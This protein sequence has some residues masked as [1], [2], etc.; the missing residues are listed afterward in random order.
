MSQKKHRIRRATQKIIENVVEKI[1]S[2]KVKSY[3]EIIKENW[4]FLVVLTIGTIIL[5]V[6]GMHGDF[7]SDDYAMI[8]NNPQIKDIGFAVK[9]FNVV[10]VS[11]YILAMTLGVVPWAYHTFS[12]LLYLIFLWIGFVFVYLIVEKRAAMITMLLFAVLPL[13]VEAVSWN[14]GKPYLYIAIFILL[15]FLFYLRYLSDNNKKYLFASLAAF[16]FIFVTDHPRPMALIPII[17][18]YLIIANSKEYWKKTTKLFP[19]LGVLLVIMTILAIPYIKTRIS[20]VNGGYNASESIF[21]NPFF[22]Y[23][24]GIPKYLQLMWMPFDLTLYHTMFVFPVKLNWMIFLNL[25][26]LIGYSYFK[27]KRIFFALSFF[28]VALLPSMAPVKVSWLVA[29]RY[30][31]LPSLGF[32]IFAGILLERIWVK[33]KYIIAIVLPVL[34]IFYAER[35]FLRNI[36]WQ[37]NHK[38]WVNT[39]QVSPNS[40]N[41]WNNIGDDYDKLKQFENAIKGFTQSTIVKVNYA[42]AYHNRANIFFKMGRL[43]LA[44]DS[45]NVA[46]YYSPTLYQTYLSL[47]QID[48][49]ENKLDLAIEH[50]SKAVEIEPTNPQA[51]YVLAVVYAQTGQLSQAQQLLESILR[52]APGYKPAE[53][54]LRQLK[55]S[56]IGKS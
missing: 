12:L 54:A 48:M 16:F 24:T 19:Y 6:N 15:S 35:T 3:R 47:T 14:S 50:A 51:A 55:L 43:D 11:N 32:C 45:Y 28:V 41:A 36:D 31:F 56:Q 8:L 53:D 30:G 10:D 17:G 23:P 44:R 42:D 38:L 49:M 22:Q 4:I 40:H 52:S 46:L 39:C 20:S 9:A 25:F 26:A 29:E 37:T 33:N 34:M 5:Y 27:D 13:H 7:V 18:L 21:Y 2:I 1:H